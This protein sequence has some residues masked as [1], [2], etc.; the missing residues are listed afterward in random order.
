[1]AAREMT[2]RVKAL[3]EKLFVDRYPFCCVKQKLWLK[4]YQ[5]T[6]GAPAMERRAHM[7]DKVMH[8]FPIFI[9]DGEL[10]VGNGASKPMGMEVNFW[11]GLWSEKEIEA[12]RNETD[13]SMFEV[14]P[15]CADEMLKQNEYWKLHNFSRRMETLFNEKYTVP[16]L[17]KGVAL[18]PWKPG[19]GWSGKC[20]S[21]LGTGPYQLISVEYDQILKKGTLG[22]AEEAQAELDELISH[23]FDEMK[24]KEF[25]KASIVCMKAMDHLGQRFAKLA[26]EKAAEEKD[27]VRKKE[28]LQIAEICHQVPGRPARN[29][30]EAIQCVWF[31]F[32]CMNP[33]M[34]CSFG[35]M[36]QYL[37]PY[38]KADIEAGRITDEEVIELLELLRI[39][40]MELNRTGSVV[41]RQKWSGL[42]KWH[43]CIIG[44][45]DKQGNDATNELSFL[46]LEAAYRA[47][48]PHHTITLRVH[49]KM[50]D[51][52]LMKAV[53]CQA[54]GL[55]LPAFISDS[56]YMQYM[57]DRGV[58]LEEARDFTIGGCID[59]QLP[60]KSRTMA[61]PMVVVPLGLEFAINNGKDFIKGMSIGK[62][63][64][65]ETTVKD[66]E[67]LYGRLYEEL[68]WMA[69]VTGEHNNNK[70]YIINDMFPDPITSTF[71]ND[72][73]KVGRNYL[74]RK[75]YYDNAVTLCCVG[76]VNLANEL[77]AIKK[78]VYVDKKYTLEQIIRGM[79]ENW[80]GEENEAIRKDCKD[81]PKYGNDDPFVD[82]ILGKLYEDWE[83]IAKT[84]PNPY[85]GTHM[86]ACISITAH[87][88][89]G[90]LT[91]ATADGRFS[92][93]C[94]ADGG[95]SPEGGTDT[96]GPLALL[97]SC[98]KV[99]QNH[100]QGVLLNM[101]F[102]PSCLKT[103]ED[104]KKFAMMIKT[105]LT[106]GGKHMQFNIVNA[107]DLKEAQVEPEKHKELMVR[108]AGY[109]TY[110]T[111]L[112]RAMQ[113][114]VIGR[115]EQTL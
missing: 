34:T 50:D 30:R 2:P 113:N 49:D 102:S 71:M 35:R 90:Q 16:F 98:L 45:V 109:S 39:K 32:L 105:Y 28:L 31:A 44:G 24:K 1:M 101:K 15:D 100:L 81:A 111:A 91:G 19:V 92:G 77:A 42:A 74:D 82:E 29:F 99:N 79:R 3:K 76:M 103:E 87:W 12:L 78:L 7:V 69:W 64:G 27:P 20:E 88:P 6:E 107:S 43:N 63:L 115:T 4:A 48:T 106:H 108:I 21:G 17:E 104:K 86:S 11:S 62:D 25:L 53:E 22:Y 65:D 57:L 80:Q 37:Y 94:L 85:G 38:Y 41:H 52:L 14:D 8:E 58:S 72:S 23:T 59:V 9:Q 51:R 66:F 60:G 40:D 18:P 93:D 83:K 36:D 95:V 26:E 47:R 70:C 55:S 10:I 61:Q 54:A 112:N 75:M 67:D 97:N 110:F 56:S 33:N 46:I 114:E 89:G 5:E 96:H 84:V 13:G 73:I 68:K